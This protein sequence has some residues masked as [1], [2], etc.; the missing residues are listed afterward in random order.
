MIFLFGEI[1]LFFRIFHVSAIFS[2]F[3]NLIRYEI[4]MTEV[5]EFFM[6]HDRWYPR[7]SS[8]ILKKDI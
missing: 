4:R 6:M 7:D 5:I 2:N 3:L 1:I 8:L